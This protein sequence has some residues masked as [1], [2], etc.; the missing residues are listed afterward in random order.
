MILTKHALNIGLEFPLK[1]RLKY[2]KQTRKP[3]FVS[4]FSRYV[5]LIYCYGE[6][7]ELR[8]EKIT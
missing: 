1:T 5:S 7:N 6:L 2:Y 4:G 8:N 3:E